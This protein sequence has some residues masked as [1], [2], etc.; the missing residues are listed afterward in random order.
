MRED[1]EEFREETEDNFK[2]VFCRLDEIEEEVCDIRKESGKMDKK[3][4][5]RIEF[6]NVVKK[7]QKIEREIAR[8]K[9]ER[10]K[11]VN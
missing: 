9:K 2:K 3:K 11:I 6:E 5:N 1:F 8:Q 10:A 4:V 7:I